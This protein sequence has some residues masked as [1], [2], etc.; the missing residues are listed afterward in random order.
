MLLHKSRI[1][2]CNLFVGRLD[3]G[4]NFIKALGNRTV[5]QVGVFAEKIAETLYSDMPTMLAKCL[6]GVGCAG[7]WKSFAKKSVVCRDWHPHL[8]AFAGLV[9]GG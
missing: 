9:P 5:G 1:I 7:V 3:R 2:L 8:H 4:S 6:A